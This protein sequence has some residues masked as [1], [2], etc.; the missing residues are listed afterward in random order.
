[1]ANEHESN[2]YTNQPT[3]PVNPQP[4]AQVP[5]QGG[6]YHYGAPQSNLPPQ[7]PTTPPQPPKKSHGGKAGFLALCMVLSLGCGLGGGFLGTALYRGVNGDSSTGTVLYQSVENNTDPTTT[8]V[9][10]V[11][12]MVQDSVVAITTE[13]VATDNFFGQYITSGAGSGVV[14]SEDGYMVTNNH[15]VAGATQI[16]VTMQD[17]TQYDAELVGTDESNDI[18]VIKVDASGLQPATMGNS[19]DLLV[20]SE[21]I[22]VGNPLG[23]LSGTVTNGIISS[24]DRELTI[25]GETY[26]LLQTNAAINPGNSGGGLFN[27]KGELVG[28]VNAKSGNTSA[29]TSIEGLGFA[30]PIDTV[31]PLV[32]DLIEHG[33]VTGRVQL[34]VYLVDIQDE[35][36]AAQYRVFD[37]GCYIARVGENS[38]AEKA[39]LQSGDRIVSINGK[40]I[41]SSEEVAAI[42]DDS[43][44]GDTLEMVV[45]TGNTERTVK[46]TLTEYHAASSVNTKSNLYRD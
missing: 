39:G 3:S 46:V 2:L 24:L 31:K 18:A 41:Q 21:V 12:A 15:V 45:A 26:H 34:G 6:Q 40:E 25:D 44:V 4:Y 23:T 16:Q 30:I 22:A 35:R 27:Y 8:A 43:S 36:T 17:G 9:A 28:I 7:H 13:T 1:M 11:A 42:I 5:P 37:F 32:S 29:G 10:D 20:G 33:Y 19:E 38:D 14:I